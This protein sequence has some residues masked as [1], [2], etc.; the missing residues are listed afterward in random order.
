MSSAGRSVLVTGGTRGIGKAIALRF[1][2]TYK[3]WTGLRI[4][5]T[6]TVTSS[7][8]TGSPWRRAVSSMKV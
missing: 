7:T 3:R 1:A 6:R 2:R 4:G 8:K 5:R